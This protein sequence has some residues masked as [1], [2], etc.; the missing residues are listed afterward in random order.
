MV[1]WSF[2]VWSLMM[3]FWIVTLVICGTGY[4]KLYALPKRNNQSEQ[5]TKLSVIVAA[6][7]EEL[8]IGRT[9]REL[10]AQTYPAMELIVVNDRSDDRTA[11]VLRELANEYAATSKSFQIV[12]IEQLPAGWLGKN[13][14]LWQGVQHSSGECLLFADA[15]IRFHPETL[16]HAM[17]FMRSKQ[18]D[19]LAMSPGFESKTIGLRGFIGLFLFALNLVLRPWRCNDDTQRTHGVGI[20]AFN[21]IRRSV[22]DAVGTHESIALRPDDDLILGTRVKMLGFKQ[23]FVLGREFLTVEWYPSIAEAVRGLEKNI[24]AG[25]GYNGW[26][27]AG[28]ILGFFAQFHLPFWLALYGWISIDHSLTWKFML[29]A[30]M[31]IEFMLIGWTSWYFSK[32]KPWEIILLPWTTLLVAYTL[33]RSVILAL[34][35]GGVYWRGTFYHLRELKQFAKGQDGV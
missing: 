10:L 6:K 12:T 20:G 9:V 31:L 16:E 14:A 1:I 34:V 19:H 24:F 2:V 3:F 11:E 8:S 18:A 17:A 21:L 4:P 29:S 33:A 13:H 5:V 25:M 30:P 27:A 28:A 15:D 23:R 32:W 7:N 35:R 22:Y 26:R